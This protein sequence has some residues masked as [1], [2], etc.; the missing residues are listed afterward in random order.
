MFRR[1]L[2]TVAVAIVLAPGVAAGEK[3][4]ALLAAVRKGDAAAVKN[5]IAQGA[6]ANAKFRYDRAILSFA[7]DRGNAEIVKALLDGGADPNAKDS[8]YTATAMTWAV[9]KG[10]AEIVKML[11]EKGAT[12]R[13]DALLSGA[14]DGHTELVKMLLG[15]GGW[16]AETLSGAYGRAERAKNEETLAALKAAG[17]VPPPKPDY[18]IP[19]ADL[20]KYAGKYTSTTQGAPEVT[21]TVKDG[22]LVGGPPGQSYTLGAFDRENFT[23]IEF[24]V[25]RLK[26]KFDGDKV[27]GMQLKQG[28]FEAEY[29]RIEEK[30]E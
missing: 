16:K 22:K 17:A 26:F 8:F 19:E 9:D 10:Y 6:D 13:E 23:L 18:K 15:L 30:K 25:V 2:M 5:L 3:E 21:F 28:S 29:K 14:G 27:V 11:L 24:D 7:A 1:F 20:P 12:G 4:E